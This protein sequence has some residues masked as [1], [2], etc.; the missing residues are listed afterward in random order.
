MLRILLTIAL[1]CAVALAA[2]CSAPMQAANEKRP[3][4]TTTPVAGAPVN[5]PTTVAKVTA[6]CPL[7]SADEL[8]ALLGGSSSQTS[9]TGYNRKLWIEVGVRSVTYPPV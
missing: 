5:T 3:S 8:R 7:L 9:V 2:G 4:P 1:V 6:A